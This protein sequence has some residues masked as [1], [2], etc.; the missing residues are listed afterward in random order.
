M[1]DS[2]AA[3]LRQQ[4]AYELNGAALRALTGRKDFHYRAAVLYDGLQPYPLQAPHVLLGDDAP[5]RDL[6]AVADSVALRGRHSDAALHTHLRPAPAIERLIFEVLEQL[7]VETQIPEHMLG[8]RRN[9]RERFI[10]WADGFYQSGLAESAVGLLL[11]TVTTM[12]WARLNSAP[13]TERVTDLIEGSRAGLV[14]ALG[15]AMQGLRRH[16]GD[17]A[18]YAPHALFIAAFI[19][20]T[21]SDEQALRRDGA[22]TNTRK[23]ELDNRAVKAFAFLLDIDNDTADKALPLADAQ[24]NTKALSSA[25]SYRVFTTQFDTQVDAASL[26]RPE[27]LRDYRE[28]LDIWIQAQAISSTRLA[29]QLQAA[30][31]LPVSEGWNEGELEGVLNGARLAQLIASPSEPRVFKQTRITPRNDCAVSFLMDCSGSMKTHVQSVAVLVDVFARAMDRVNIHNE[32]L[33]FSTRTWNGGRAHKAWL[34]AGQP[35]EAGRLNELNHMVFKSHDTRWKQ[36]RPAIAALL[37]PDVFREGIDGEA[38]DWACKR[39]LAIDCKR[40][41][42]VVIS[43]G[44]PMDSATQAVNGD[45]YLDKHLRHVVRQYSAQGA[46]AIHGV[47][48]GL[49]LSPYYPSNIGIDA[50]RLIDSALLTSMVDLIR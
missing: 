19:A 24:H 26:V 30:L 32:I 14:A 3:L 47:G 17:Q 2:R 10:N 7:R 40:R 15:H 48:V 22:A 45:A 23:A 20:N 4:H 6:R 41:I 28:Q 46:I 34:A 38:V 39:L 16:C 11:L 12:C 1:E 27:Q 25:A 5:M 8:Q 43:D 9:V 35:P 18:T 21:V 49:D 29:R 33:G 50:S 31:A 36:A 13:L 44:C 42:L 37:K